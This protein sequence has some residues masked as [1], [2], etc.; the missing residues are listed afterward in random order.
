MKSFVGVRNRLL[1]SIT[2][3]F[4]VPLLISIR[5]N[6]PFHFTMNELESF[7][8]GTIG[9]DLVVYLE[10]KKFTLMKNYERH[11]CKHII[12]GYE[13]DQKG[14]GLMQFYF[15]GTGHYSLPVVTSVLAYLLLMPE[16]WSSFYREF[17]KGRCGKK[18]NDLDKMSHNQLV[19][20]R[21]SDLQKQFL[22]NVA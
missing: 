12:F 8:D 15:L 7:P 22:N 21:T 9:K 5:K 13:M 11:D 2:H 19:Q 3:N 17:K 18:I 1:E 10:K 16:E 20:M 6:E 14:E 4:A